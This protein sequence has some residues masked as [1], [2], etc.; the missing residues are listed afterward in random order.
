MKKH[1][2][3]DGFDW[4]I[5]DLGPSSPQLEE[6]QRGFSFYKKWAFGYENECQRKKFCFFYCQSME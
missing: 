6:P 2:I 1:N 3:A 5:M 4:I